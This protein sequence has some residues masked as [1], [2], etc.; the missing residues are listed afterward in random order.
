MAARRE[1]THGRVWHRPLLLL[2]LSLLLLLVL[3]LLPILLP[4]LWLLLCWL[5]M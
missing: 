4:I 5:T 2:L 1:R 3:T